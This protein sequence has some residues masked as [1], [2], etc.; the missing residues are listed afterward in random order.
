MDIEVVMQS[1]KLKEFAGQCGADLVGVADLASLEGIPTEPEDLFQGYHRAVSIAVRLAD[2]VIDTIE[3]V[4]TPIYAQHYLKVNAL[5]DDL[6]LRVAQF[7]QSACAK[8]LP[9]PAS[10]ALNRELWTSYVSHK[11]VAVAAGLGWQG[12]SLLV[13]TPEYGPRVRLVTVLTDLPFT[14]DKPV[15]NRCGKCSQCSDACPVQAIRNV[16][17]ES[18]YSSREEA[19]FFERCVDRVVKQ[20]PQ[21]PFIE[22]PICGVCVRACPWGQKKTNAEKERATL[23]H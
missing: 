21:L 18:H 2:G 13:V 16:N 8:A 1:E 3:D 17:T 22:L 20:N 7:I 11:A 6:A 14:P 15:K 9:I 19:L 10:Q 23:G 12:K 4:P 5:L